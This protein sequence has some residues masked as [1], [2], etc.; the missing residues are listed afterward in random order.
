[1]GGGEWRFS[2]SAGAAT[3]NS[4]GDLSPLQRALLPRRAQQ[5]DGGLGLRRP[6]RALPAAIMVVHLELSFY[7]PKD[8]VTGELVLCNQNLDEHDNYAEEFK[9]SRWKYVKEKVMNLK[10]KDAEMIPPKYIVARW[11]SN[12]CRHVDMNK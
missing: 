6:G 5:V 12:A 9:P 3:S 2:A 7:N 11:T 4:G 1:M 8:S 10:D